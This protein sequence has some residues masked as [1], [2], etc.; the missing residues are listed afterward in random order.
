MQQSI[1]K[2]FKDLFSGMVLGYVAKIALLSLVLSGVVIWLFGGV[3]STFVSGYL[4]FIPWEWLQQSGLAIIK[5]LISYM[6]F[7]TIHAILTSLMIEPLLKKLI[8]KHYPTMS[9]VGSPEIKKSVLISIKAAL[10]FLGV[11]IIT[12]PISFIPLVGAIWMLWVWSLLIK[13][14]TIYDIHSLI[15]KDT[16]KKL[17]SNKQSTIIAM[18]ASGFN[19]IP[20]LNV[21]SSVYAYIL[22]LH[23]VATQQKD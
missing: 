23:F 2:S 12:I 11:F 4:S 8:K 13:E 6:I 22:F 19:Y 20:V 1:I 21:L 9:I 10:I 5:V 14:P 17:L 16:H 18:L 15:S 7:I 3:I